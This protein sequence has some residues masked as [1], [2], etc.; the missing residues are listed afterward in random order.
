M[1]KTTFG[2]V[3]ALL[4]INGSYTIIAGPL[5]AFFTEAISDKSASQVQTAILQKPKTPQKEAAPSQQ[6]PPFEVTRL[7]LK[8]DNGNITGPCPARVN[9]GGFITTNGPGVVQYTFVRSD[10]ATGPALSM[11]FKEGGTQSLTSTW[12]LG[13]AGQPAFEGWQAIRIL[14]P[15]A[16]ESSHE[17]GA[18]RVACP[19]IA[20]V[21]D[22]S[23]SPL[24]TAT[25]QVT[26]MGFTVVHQTRDDILQRDGAGDEVF[27]A[28]PSDFLIDTSGA[29]IRRSVGGWGNAYGQRR[30]PGS[31][32]TQA[33]TATPSGGLRTGDQFPLPA[34]W[35]HTGG[36]TVG[37]AI[38]HVFFWGP[39]TQGSTAVAVIPSLWEWDNDELE[40]QLTYGSMMADLSLGP[41]IRPF[42]AHSPTDL[43]GAIKTY[44][45]LGL[46][47]RL[48]L[49]H[50][51]L[52][53]G[54]VNNR[55]IGM[56]RNG[57]RY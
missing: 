11:Q 33:G 51:P 38:S 1:R 54:E 16:M 57:D 29:E 31:S 50:G 34:P 37:G 15:N 4:L 42:I 27:L 6:Q 21:G 36:A 3:T 18:F 41:A 55:P 2:I 30:S 25:F 43:E 14:S 32:V 56:T 12:Q 26:L 9:F 23:A 47:L 40:T 49:G 10:G 5:R 19:P 17:T 28:S 35:L 20:R 45:Q 7:Q 39:I 13:E 48:S 52:G 53:L 46:P 24:L 22:A 44:S 8:A